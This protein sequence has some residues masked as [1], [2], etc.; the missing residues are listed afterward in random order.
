[1]LMQDR[2][3]YIRLRHK[4]R[5]VQVRSFSVRLGEVITGYFIFLLIK[6][7]LVVMECHVMSGYIR[8]K[9]FISG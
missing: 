7:C 3:V 8:L 9:Q 6:L 5:L 1:M 2:T 4:F